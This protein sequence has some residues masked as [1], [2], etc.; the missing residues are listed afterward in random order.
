M[1][2]QLKD[3]LIDEMVGAW[4]FGCCQALQGLPVDYFATVFNFMRW[5]GPGASA[6]ARPS[7]VYLLDFVCSSIHFYVLLIFLVFSVFCLVCLCALLVICA[8]WSSTG[9]GLI[10]WL[11][12]VVS[13]CEFVTFPLVSWVRCGTGLYPFLIF[14]PLLTFLIFAL[15]FLNFDL[16]DLRDNSW[17]S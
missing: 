12:F 11:S 14:A 16:Y 3:L 13:N 1:M 4:C 7:R 6:V 2:V 17:I 15:S 5:L 9:K 8:L 10:S